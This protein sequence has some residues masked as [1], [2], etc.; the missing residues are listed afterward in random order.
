M[1]VA[2]LIYESGRHGHNRSGFDQQ[3]RKYTT[4]PNNANFY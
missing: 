2:L 3:N 1:A 4:R